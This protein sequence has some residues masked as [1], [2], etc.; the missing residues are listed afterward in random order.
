[1]IIK[2]TI[3]SLCLLLMG[4]VAFSQNILEVKDISQSNDVFSSANDEAAVL[5]RCNHTIPLKF[6]S[7]MDKSAVPFRTELQGSDS[8]YYIAFPTGNR[9][10]GRELA[11]SSPGYYSVSISLELQPKQLLSYQITDPNALV[12]A[13]CYRGHRNKG[14]EEIKNS[15]Y[16]EARNQ[17]I[18]ARECTDCNV[19]EN[20]SNIALADSLILYRQKGDEAYKLL[21]Y[22]KASNYYSM[23]LALNAY[24][25]YASNR[26]TICV[27]NFTD[28]CNTL[29]TKAEYY[30]SEKEY[31]KAKELYEKVVEKECTNMSIAVERLN[32]ISSLL[33]AKK[34]HARVFT[35]EYRKDVPIGFSYGHYNMHKAGGF[36]QMD[37]NGNVFKAIR[38]D[39]KYGDEKFAEMNMSFGWTIKI[40]AP[41]WIHFGP[42]FTGKMYYGTYLD[43]QYPK[44]GFGSD[45]WQYLDK[46]KMGNEEVLATA[47]G[48]D[49]APEPYQ[50]GWEKAN[51]AFA[52]SPVV[53]I[54]AKYSYFAVRLTYQ[55][56]W[57][58]QKD[59]QDFMGPS[60]VSVGV[61][62]AF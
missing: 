42:G 56:R 24:D 47:P 53:G 46:S 37:F 58:V 18:V 45:D 36:F 41:I 48:L 15:N 49:E 55:Y 28:E 21:D 20:E 8:L 60:R 10:R 38:S 3:L 5:I 2:K 52:V 51:L 7:S 62:V 23:I 13:G 25:N 29:Y 44:K 61:G 39:C 6:S 16:E 50:K 9:Y 30:F 12:D 33:R 26:N 27:R 1:M 17:F 54:T 31:D 11:I 43:K 34:D 4:G 22:V 35:Y 32:S 40:A 14:M 57:S 59:L 19:E